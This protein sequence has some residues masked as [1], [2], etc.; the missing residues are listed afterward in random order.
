MSGADLRR[1]TLIGTV[2]ALSATVAV[3]A[4][5]V[6]APQ[7]GGYLKA[8][9]VVLDAPEAQSE[10]SSLLRA[11]VRAD[12]RASDSLS[13]QIAYELAPRIQT[14]RSS[15]DDSES[16]AGAYRIGDL[17]DAALSSTRQDASILDVVQNLDRAYL[18]AATPL[19]DITVG[20]QPLAFGS[21]RS[22]NPT[23]VLAPFAYEALDKEER[24]GV[25]AVRLQAP[26]GEMSE[27]DAGVVLGEDLARDRSAAYV[28]AKGYLL[29]TDI[30]TMAMEFRQH[31]MLG[32][33]VARAIGGAS[34]WFEGAYTSVE[35]GDTRDGFARA[36]VGADY[37]LSFGAYTFAE[38]HWNGAG[39]TNRDDYAEIAETSPYREGIV[40]F[41][42]KGYAACGVSY[43]ITMLFGANAQALLNL[44]DGSVLISSGVEYGFGQDAFIR[45][46]TFYGVGSRGSSG[47][48]EFAAYPNVCYASVSLYF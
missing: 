7:V 48:T 42:G 19:A 16:A 29:S 22:V 46:G 8:F 41:L 38:L 2:A 20:R 24:I 43:A 18:F 47:G 32:I 6:D 10:G 45:A 13:A 12:W 5:R 31:R 3:A 40:R 1:Y 37:H 17:S 34:A 26:L 36:S 30:A 9:T 23:D 28:R 25:D 35:A 14:F 15:V 21:A 4:A 39:S 11:R 33:D 27:L 44:A